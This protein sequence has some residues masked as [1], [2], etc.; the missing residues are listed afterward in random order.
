MFSA[1]LPPANSQKSRQL[2]SLKPSNGRSGR[3]LRNALQF[4]FCAVQSDGT[5]RTHC[6]LPCGVLRLIQ[7]STC[8]TFPI[9][10]SLTHCF[11]SVSTPE[12]WYCEPICTTR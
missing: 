2:M 11:A 12:P 6:P 5:G 3:P 1:Q 4:T 10:P 9:H 7:D 8:V